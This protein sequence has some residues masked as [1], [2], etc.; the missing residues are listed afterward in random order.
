MVLSPRDV[1]RRLRCRFLLWSRLVQLDPYWWELV[2]LL[3][4]GAAGGV[5]TTDMTL[6]R[7]VPDSKVAILTTLMVASTA[8]NIILSLECA[9]FRETV[10]DTQSRRSVCGEGS[11]CGPVWCNW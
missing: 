1:M 11:F 10:R 4:Y 2:L 9:H 8:M 7:W 3:M 5:L 6:T